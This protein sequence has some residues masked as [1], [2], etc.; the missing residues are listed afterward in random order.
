MSDPYAPQPE[1]VL[2]LEN[3]DEMT[4]IDRDRMKYYIYADNFIFP[5]WAEWTFNPNNTVTYQ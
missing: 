1:P 2:R 5:A 3:I 4:I